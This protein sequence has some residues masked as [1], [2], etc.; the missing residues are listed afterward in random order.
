M[1]IRHHCETPLQ[2]HQ[3]K[4]FSLSKLNG[5]GECKVQRLVHSLG[6]F[7]KS[8]YGVMWSRHSELTRSADRVYSFGRLKRRRREEAMLAQCVRAARLH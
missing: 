2:R 4:A 8:G 5:K 3:N 6:S 7:G 1:A